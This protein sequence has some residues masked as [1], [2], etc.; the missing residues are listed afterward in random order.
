MC[1]TGVQYVFS[2]HISYVFIV[3]KQPHKPS[4]ITQAYQNVLRD[5]IVEHKNKSIHKISLKN[6]HIWQK[7]SCTTGRQKNRVGSI[8][9]EKAIFQNADEEYHVKVAD[10][11]QEACK[12]LEVGFEYVTDL[13]GAKLFRKRK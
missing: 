2:R 12:L 10:P 1:C 8:N 5:P 7:S 9:L 11:L 6:Q 3:Y 13:N 4:H